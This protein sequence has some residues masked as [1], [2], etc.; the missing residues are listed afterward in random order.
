MAQGAGR[1]NPLILGR[2]D[3]QI[4]LLEERVRAAQP[5]QVV[6]PPRASR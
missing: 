3:E 5:L 1:V 2:Y 4:K 6:Q